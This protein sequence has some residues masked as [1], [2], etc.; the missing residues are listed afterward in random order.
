MSQMTSVRCL[1]Y[2][3]AAFNAGRVISIILAVLSPPCNPMQGHPCALNADQCHDPFTMLDES[4]ELFLDEI[5]DWVAVSHDVGLM[6][7]ALHYLIRD[8]GLTYKLLHKSALECDEEAQKA[9]QAFIR[10]HLVADQ[11]ITADE[12]SKDDRT[13]FQQWGQA[14]RGNQASIDADFV[15]GER[16]SIVAA[17]SVDGYV[18]TCV[19]PGSVDGDEFFDFIVEDVVCGFVFKP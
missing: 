19:V 4:P 1:G 14:P 10:D 9:F 12:S 3:C 18:G 2:L 15:R 17:M 8:A 5:R 16:Y 7:S 13:I 6:Q 11:V